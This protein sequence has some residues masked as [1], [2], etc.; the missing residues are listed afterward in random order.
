MDPIE[1]LLTSEKQGI[2]DNKIIEHLDF[3][4]IIENSGSH[5]NSFFDLLQCRLPIIACQWITK[6]F[7]N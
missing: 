1:I 4:F 2:F 6:L 3:D 7:F 5:F